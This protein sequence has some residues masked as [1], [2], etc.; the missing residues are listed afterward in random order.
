MES[1][2]VKCA[3][4]LNRQQFLRMLHVM[5][6][7]SLLS[8][9]T[10]NLLS[11]QSFF[12][13]RQKYCSIL[14][15]KQ[16]LYYQKE[17]PPKQAFLSGLNVLTPRR[18]NPGE[19]LKLSYLENAWLLRKM[20]TQNELK[21]CETVVQMRKFLSTNIIERSSICQSWPKCCTFYRVRL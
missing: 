16:L 2:K 14:A 8:H 17:Q 1:S 5:S 10:H 7:N 20:A 9:G 13:I 11:M 12:R 21:Y 4:A 15:I 18:S 6:T 3:P 19:E